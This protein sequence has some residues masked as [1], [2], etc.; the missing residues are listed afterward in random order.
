[1][2]IALL[3]ERLEPARGG[4]EA[5]GAAWAAWLA[6][7]GATVRV[8][9]LVPFKRAAWP[10]KPDSIQVVSLPERGGGVIEEG[11]RLEA[12]ARQDSDLLHDFGAGLGGD[13]F[14]PLFGLRATTQAA[15]R[16]S[17]GWRGAWRTWKRRQRR[18]ELR[19]LEA[20]Q[21]A[22]GGL[23]IACSR[24]VAADFRST[25]ALPEECIR[26]LPNT[27]DNRRFTPATAAQRLAARI[28]L[29]LPSQGTIFL[30][31]AHNFRLKGVPTAIAALARLRGQV[32][33]VRLLVVGRGPDRR[34]FRKLARRLGVADR[35]HLLGALPDAG[36]AFQAAD[37][38]VHPAYFDSGSLV[39]QEAM[40][41][42][43]PLAISVED[44]TAE[45]ITD[46]VQGWL[47]RD[48]AD[49]GEVAFQ[50]K[51]LLDPGLRGA[52]GAQARVLMLHYERRDAF[53]RLLGYA[54]EALARRR[55]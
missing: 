1:M 14:Q 55:G 20:A 32:P 6:A 30:Q 5:Y 10:A 35:V 31:V 3:M 38:M 21:V 27:I 53:R 7:Q 16:R 2:R 40:A 29:G 47:I 28:A 50:M 8:V 42:A 33:P 19:Q 11:R 44:G 34:T 49:V 39:S 41:A 52:M 9:T 48:P 46:G 51:R 43:L 13:L 23:L 54:E 18:R 17:L 25:Y 45:L 26:L 12:L 37:A 22:G 24:R 36:L 4:A 15:E